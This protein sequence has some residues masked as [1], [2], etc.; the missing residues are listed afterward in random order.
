MRNLKLVQSAHV[1]SIAQLAGTRCVDVDYDTSVLYAATATQLLTVDVNTQQ[2]D[3]HNADMF[4][5]CFNY[6]CCCYQRLPDPIGYRLSL[7]V[8]PRPP[9]L[10]LLLLLQTSIGHHI[11]S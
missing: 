8:V 10:L 3:Y 1:G 4:F 2:V 7:R 9:P 6:Y 11:T 5:H